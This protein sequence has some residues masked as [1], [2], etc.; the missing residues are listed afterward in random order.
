MGQAVLKGPELTE[1]MDS[2][3]TVL[4]ELESIDHS[5]TPLKVKDSLK[6]TK[7]RKLLRGKAA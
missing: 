2:L 1:G 7:A 3:T 4:A 5:L 6:Q